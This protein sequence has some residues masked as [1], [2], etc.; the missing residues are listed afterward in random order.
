MSMSP[1]VGRENILITSGS[2]EGAGPERQRRPA[3]CALWEDK[4]SGEHFESAQSPVTD[5]STQRDTPRILPRLNSIK[6]TLPTGALVL[7]WRRVTGFPDVT[8]RQVRRRSCRQRT[9]LEG[10]SRPRH[11]N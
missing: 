3:S 5:C 10:V 6:D 2:N 11:S 1:A 7:A 4:F 8:R 9:R